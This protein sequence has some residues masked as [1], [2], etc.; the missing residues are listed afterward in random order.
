MHDQGIPDDDWFPPKDGAQLD[1]SGAMAPRSGGLVGL[2]GSVLKG[3]AVAE[4]GV[5]K[6]RISLMP[7]ADAL[8][9]LRGRRGRPCSPAPVGREV[10]PPQT[11]FDGVR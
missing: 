7:L 8:R 11:V 2:G 10:I 3:S 4:R 5:E 6:Q 9:G 1:R